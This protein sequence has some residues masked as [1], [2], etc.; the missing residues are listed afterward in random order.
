MLAPFLLLTNYSLRNSCKCDRL[1]VDK[2]HNINILTHP[3]LILQNNKHYVKHQQLDASHVN[4]FEQH[5]LFVGKQPLCPWLFL[6]SIECLM[7]NTLTSL[8][9]LI[10]NSYLPDLFS[11]WACSNWCQTCQLL[12]LKFESLKKM[13]KQ[14][15]KLKNIL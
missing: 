15:E 14:I 12:V 4:F 7:P 3:T 5:L 11:Q 9:Y 2:Q 13:K 8:Y 1:F 10:T 6:L